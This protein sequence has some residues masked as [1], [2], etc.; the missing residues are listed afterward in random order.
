M[1]STPTQTKK[2]E[3]NSPSFTRTRTKLTDKERAERRAEAK[4][5]REQREA[6]Y[7]P[8]TKTYRKSYTGRAK[9]GRQ[10]NLTALGF[11]YKTDLT[12]I[13]R[14]EMLRTYGDDGCRRMGQGQQAFEHRVAKIVSNEFGSEE[15][16]KDLSSFNLKDDPTSQYDDVKYKAFQLARHELKRAR[17]L[18]HHE[19]T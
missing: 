6:L 1:T 9:A 4:F 18:V 7:G 14:D 2:K 5:N 12:W 13:I 19:L 15:R 10:A 8:S 17:E 16:W 3:A 11:D